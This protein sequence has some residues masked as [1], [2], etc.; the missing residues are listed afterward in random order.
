[1]F[2][3]NFKPFTVGNMTVEAEHIKNHKIGGN[4]AI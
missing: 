2:D 1:V 3:A 4:A